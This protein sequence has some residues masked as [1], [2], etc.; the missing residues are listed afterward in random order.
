MNWDDREDKLDDISNTNVWRHS[1]ECPNCR[2]QTWSFCCFIPDFKTGR[3]KEGCNECD[4]KAKSIWTRE[5]TPVNGAIG[6]VV[7]GVIGV[8]GFIAGYLLK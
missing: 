8:I 2:S 7:I 5:S 6:F 3:I 1:M 4:D